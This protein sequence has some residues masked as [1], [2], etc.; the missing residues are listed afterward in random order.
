ME[1]ADE[2]DA[3][4]EVADVCV[5]IQKFMFANAKLPYEREITCHLGIYA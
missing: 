5:Q 2:A 1:S 3:I 4:T